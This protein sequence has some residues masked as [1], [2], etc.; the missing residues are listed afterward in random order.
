MLLLLAC[1]TFSGSR[2][3][4]E[5]IGAELCDTAEV[6][7]VLVSSYEPTT[8]TFTGAGTAPVVSVGWIGACGYEIPDMDPYSGCETPD[9]QAIVEARTGL[10]MASFQGCYAGGDY[11]V[12]G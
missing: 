9:L 5:P 8:V 11:V 4:C 1:V 3:G 7:E 6:D 2:A 10:A 12:G